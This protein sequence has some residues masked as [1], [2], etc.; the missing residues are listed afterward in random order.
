MHFAGSIVVPDSVRNP[1]EYY[2]NNTSVARSLLEACVEEGVRNFI[3]SSTAAIYGDPTLPAVDEDTP[4]RPLSP[5]GTSK[6]M[7]ELM[8]RDTAAAYPLR[9]VALRYFNV[10]GAD[11]RGR[12]G[13]NSP[14]A[15]H[16][17]K[18]ACEAALGL[19]THV[20]IFGTDY[21]TPDGTGVRDY[22]HVTDLVD[23]HRLA[24]E[25][26]RSGGASLV[27]NCGYGRGYSVREVIDAV[28]TAS[29]S[30]FAIH[31]A[32]RRPG[33]CAQIV[34]DSRRIVGLLN[35]QPRYEDLG[36]IVTHALSWEKRKLGMGMVG[37]PPPP[38][39]TVLALQSP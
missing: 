24:L 13:Q 8:L 36:Q 29:A 33:D 7:T 12:T 27:L 30:A 4:P 32:P 1:L 34:A 31:E 23:A 11:P 6:L 10:A 18:V 37:I 20:D 17:I 28:R 9:Y 38:H 19:R 14:R 25:H 39:K 2:R 22:I 5:Y 21:P 16:L 35:W 15:T 26:L 3:F